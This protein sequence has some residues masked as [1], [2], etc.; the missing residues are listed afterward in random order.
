MRLWTLL[1]ILLVLLTGV[2]PALAEEVRIP[3][4]PEDAKPISPYIF[5]LN[6]GADLSHVTA[7]SYRLG[8]NRLSAYN[9]ENNASNAG[10]DWYHHSDMYLMNHVARQF[11]L[12]PGGA[13]LNAVHYA[14]QNGVPYTLVTL[15]MLGYVASDRLG[16]VPEDMT[17]PSPY[18]V[19]VENRKNG[20]LSLTPDT[21]DDAVYM[22]EFV[23]LLVHTFGT[24]EE[25]GVRGYSLDNEPSLWAHTHARVQTN[26]LL[27]TELVDKS[28]DLASAVKAID[29]SAEVFGPALF[30]YYAYLGL[31]DA[32][33]WKSIR[34]GGYRWFIDY[35]L[36]MMRMAE[37]DTG[38][39]LLDVLDIHYYT[40]AKGA[41]GVRCCTHYDREDCNAARM[42]AF[43]SLYDASYREDSWITDTGAAFF[44]LLPKLQGAIDQYYPGTKLAFSEYNFGGGDHITGGIAQADALGTFAANGVYFASLWSFD[45]NEFQL[46][47]INMFTNYDGQ[48]SGIGDTLV[49]SGDHGDFS[50]YAATDGQNP[51][52]LTLLVTH[53]GSS[54]RPITF[55]LPEGTAYADAEVYVLAGDEPMIR[56][57]PDAARLDGSSVTYTLE[58][59][60]VAVIVL[61]AE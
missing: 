61:K 9:W 41:C 58:P 22:D 31:N 1:V 14:A 49:Y 35:Y 48:G 38:M 45:H 11:K 5:G 6:S 37:E 19:R 44:P 57:R 15:Q 4:A 12:K 30:G 33:D 23:N 29:P 20:E 32:P 16:N 55:T 59:L 53:R 47:A 28:I 26:P 3:L 50:V 34:L 42:N 39:R 7:K 24:A 36:D 13:A 51:G 54:E 60:S 2:F 40:E 21:K 27:C 18:W 10:S 43:R 46:A 17:A 52:R 8:G 25:G 56:V